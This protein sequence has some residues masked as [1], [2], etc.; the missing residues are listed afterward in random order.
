[1]N[2]G[3][4]ILHYQSIEDTKKCVVS[5]LE[6]ID[7]PT[8]V[9]VDNASP[10]KSGIKLQNL[11]KDSLNITVLLLDTN[12]GFAG[13]NNI[14]YRYLRNNFNCDYICCINNDTQL[15]EYGFEDE[16]DNL[17]SKYCFG[18]FA[19]AVKLTDGSIQSFNPRIR[20]MD[21]YENE[22]AN[23]KQ[24]TTLKEYQKNIHGIGALFIYFPKMMRSV[25]KIKQRI[26]PPYPYAM[27]N[28]VLHGC[29]LVFS[30]LFIEKYEEAFCPKTF[31]YRE[32]E[33]LYIKTRSAGMKTLYCGAIKILHNEDS[34]TNYSFPDKEEKYQFMREN[35]IRSTKI[36]IEE[37]RKKKNEEWLRGNQ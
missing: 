26:K 28:V 37:L 20:K 12:I 21:Y 35:Q 27:E 16:I 4:E 30:K 5:I 32:E 22:I 1:M 10:N 8:I 23:Y 25:R 18:V 13:G 19:P 6:Y 2:I 33:L 34:A 15:L 29:F 24:A 9:V 11:Y 3:F 14:G 17:F 36:L 31:M 7:N